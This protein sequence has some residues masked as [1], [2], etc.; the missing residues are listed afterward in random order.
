MLPN[1]KYKLPSSAFLK[2]CS[3]DNSEYST[4]SYLPF[5]LHT[6]PTFSVGSLFTQ[7]FK[8]AYKSL[9][10][11]NP[12]YKGSNNLFKTLSTPIT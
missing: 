7:H 10:A 12:I 6:I 4:I 9:H 3:F 8:L 5:F 11:V 2:D 1:S